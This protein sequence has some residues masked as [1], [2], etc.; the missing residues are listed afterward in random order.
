LK[1]HIG[2]L[3]EY[4]L[5]ISRRRGVVFGKLQPL[6]LLAYSNQISADSFRRRK[7]IYSIGTI[8][9]TANASHIQKFLTN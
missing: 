3:M 2:W 6:F 1:A 5:F 8:H 7:M 9:L 4:L